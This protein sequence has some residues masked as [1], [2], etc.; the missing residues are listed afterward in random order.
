MLG[1]FPAWEYKDSMISLELQD[2]LLLFTDGITEA[3]GA[4]AQEFGVESVASYAQSNS[5]KSAQELSNGLLAQV[6][7]F[8]EDHF[9]DDATVVVVA[10]F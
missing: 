7:T 10:A 5:R 6:S 9:Q 1:V 2:R 8:C 3:E 4:N